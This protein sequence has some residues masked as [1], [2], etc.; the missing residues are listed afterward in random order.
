MNKKKAF[1]M[2]TALLVSMTLYGCTSNNSN[3]EASPGNTEPS[4][5]KPSQLRIL[6]SQAP[7]HNN[8]DDMLVWQEYETI[9]GIRIDW[10]AV[11]D[12]DFV[13]K[14]NILL[15]GG[16]LPDAIFRARL[17]N[18]DLAA[19]G[20]DGTFIPLND[21]IEQYAPNFKKLM[22][23]HP[24][25]KKGITQVDGNIYSLPHFSEFQSANYGYKMFINQAWMDQLNIL[26]PT[27]TDEFY[28]LLAAFKTGDANGNGAMDE[29]PLTAPSLPPVID[30]LKGFWGLG[31]RGMVHQLVDVDEKTGKVRFIPTD[32]RYKSLLE[33]V[34]KLYQEQL[35]DPE[36]FTMN[37]AKL[38]AKG[39][40]NT[41]G[42]FLFS[43]PVPIGN[44]YKDD[45]VGMNALKGPYGDQM[46]S[47]VN[48][49]LR[50]SG[51]FV[52]TK[53]NK[54]PEET[55]KWVDYW[56]SDEGAR[57][58][59]MGVEGKTYTKAA[60]G[61][62]EYTAEIANNPNGLTLDEAAG[63]YLAWPGGSF[64]GI[65]MGAYTKSGSSFPSAIAATELVQ[66]YFPKEIWPEFTY[67]QEETDLL[68][69]IG[70]DISTYVNEMQVKFVSGALSFSEWD[71]YVSTLDKMGLEQYMEVYAQAYERF[72]K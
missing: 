25:V 29:V 31:N 69:S 1:F 26:A 17:T 72:L 57:L 4:Q 64:P 28:N 40:A 23:K 66:D 32:E 51:A 10:N 21:L 55:M 33:F 52:I 50:A 61:T 46:I 13:E 12:A 24:E 27:T 70:N 16:D 48:P 14:R 60:D 22:D 54:Y 30:A 35:L 11:P 65:Q 38:T 42:A 5:S 53:A 63:Q 3:E 37:T 58:F 67:S 20:G 15:A 43:N 47:A 49:Q 59:L 39:E 2:I 62:Y 9:S 34:S 8:Y 41:I 7:T 19:R 68:S 36:I 44:T 6:M 56:Y 45:Y 18:A 71:K